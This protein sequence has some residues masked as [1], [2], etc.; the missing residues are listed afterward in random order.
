[1]SDPLTVDRPCHPT[2]THRYRRVGHSNLICCVRCGQGKFDIAGVTLAPTPPDA[3]LIAALDRVMR[4]VVCGEWYD[5]PAN[6]PAVPAVARLHD[7][8]A[9]MWALYDEFGIDPGDS[10]IRR[11][12]GWREA[13]YAADGNIT[14]PTPPDALEPDDNPTGLP[15]CHKCGDVTFRPDS[16]DGRRQARRCAGC[17]QTTGNCNCAPAP[18]AAPCTCGPWVVEGDPMFRTSKGS[19]HKGSC[20][21][22]I[23][24]TP[25][26]ALR[27]AAQAVVDAADQYRQAVR[28][29]DS[30]AMIHVANAMAYHLSDTLRLALRTDRDLSARRTRRRRGMDVWAPVTPTPERGNRHE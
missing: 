25:P 2:T 22:H 30:D 1:M 9:A 15:S 4:N 27:D 3:P 24:S 10:Y 23:A 28:G 29:R 6:D 26:D 18:S 12:D 16:Y 5:D 17:Q 20:P 14:V 7:A 19:W 21:L 8:E 13:Y 11:P